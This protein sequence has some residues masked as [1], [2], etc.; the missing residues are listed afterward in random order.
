MDVKYLLV[1]GVAIGAVPAGAQPSR[2]AR[3]EQNLL[4]AVTVV[5]RPTLRFSLAE[6]MAHHKVPAVSVALIDGGRLTWARA[7]GERAPGMP[8]TNETLFQAASISKPV[9]AAAMLRAVHAGKLRL[10]RPI[11]EHLVRWKVPAAEHKPEAVT[12]RGLLSHT[13]GLSVSGFQGY[14]PGTPMPTLPQL[15]AGEKPANS[16]PVRPVQAPGAWRYSGGGVSVAQLALEDATGR[17][18]EAV[19]ADTVLRPLGMRSSSFA[20]PLDPARR[21]RA[22]V[23]HDGE[24]KPIAGRWHVYPEKAAAGLW[25][26]PTDLARF[27]TWVM[28][29]LRT[30]ADPA[31]RFVATHLTQ[32]QPGARPTPN[33]R[34]GLGFLLEGEGPATRFWHN[35]VNEGFRAYLL[36][37]PETG[38]GAVIMTN[39]DGG[40]ALTQELL[41]SLA[42]EYGW[43]ERFHQMLVPTP[44]P[45]TH[46]P[47]LVG[48]YR[49]GE[50][51]DARIAIRAEGD[52]LVAAPARGAPA[53]LVPLGADAFVNPGTGMRYRFKDGQLFMEAPNGPTR[54]AR[55]EPAA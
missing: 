31:Q 11:N 8:A 22:A 37:F 44:G 36:G 35:G 46:L 13:A 16:E 26:T 3:V 21:A 29:G 12:L 19:L 24:G 54:T 10:D 34:M 38:Q 45:A 39:G 27:A 9:S 30:P 32:P 23:A 47:D 55:R 4:P 25:T 1:L 20:Q 43:P 41:R 42:L 49:W 7:W 17:P 6:R 53:R 2:L 52:Q 48:S 5:G 51:P 14:A 50:E 15:L 28:A 33:M 18:F 40:A